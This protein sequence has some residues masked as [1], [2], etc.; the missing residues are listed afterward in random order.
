MRVSVGGKIDFSQAR[1]RD[2]VWWKRLQWTLDEAYRLES[3]N[4]NELMVTKLAGQMGL[5]RISEE[6]FSRL[7][8]AANAAVN[9][10]RQLIFNPKEPT[11]DAKSYKD[12]W[13][14]VFG[15][16]DAPE[17]QEKIDKFVQALKDRHSSAEISAKPR[18]A[19]PSRMSRKKTGE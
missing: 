14:S 7:Q 8:E 3:L 4:Y 1:L 6:S 13:S 11:V 5:Y 10:S 9:R 2:P 18:P 15:D 12:Q 19:R 16:L 17:T